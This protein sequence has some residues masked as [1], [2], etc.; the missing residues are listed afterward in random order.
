MPFSIRR[1]RISEQGPLFAEVERFFRE[2]DWNVER[3]PTGAALHMGFTGEHG[4]WRCIAAVSEE[5]EQF[6]F[7]AVT[8]TKVPLEARAAAAEYLM[9][10]SYGLSV[11]NFEM[12]FEDGEVRFKT[13][14]D[15]EGGELT[16]GMI[17]NLVYGNCATTD[18]YLHGLMKVV[19]GGAQPA[20][21]VRE[22]EA[23]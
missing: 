23:A 18:R 8:E 3:L 6:V 20:V 14:I 7:Y 2:D 22:A 4:S 17:R 15:V 1:P 13:S 19:Y 12:D 11:G 21:A 9:R 5:R 10:A 16:Q